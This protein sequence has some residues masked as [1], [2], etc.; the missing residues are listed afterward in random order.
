MTDDE[1][2]QAFDPAKDYE[3]TFDEDVRPLMSKV[4][5]IC[6]AR[7]IPFVAVFQ[8]SAGVFAEHCSIPPTASPVIRSIN[9]FVE[10][11]GD[12]ESPLN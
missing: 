2:Y 9:D 11:C 3:D 8:I 12:V 7:G 6:R 5:E 4:F 10:Q 1:S